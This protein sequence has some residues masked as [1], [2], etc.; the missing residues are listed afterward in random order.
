V[1]YDRMRRC[2][3]E[4]V[5][6]DDNNRIA[7][8]LNETIF[9]PAGDRQK[10]DRGSLVLSE[11]LLTRAMAE[12]A[13]LPPAF[14]VCDT[15]QEEGLIAHILAGSVD[16]TLIE[17]YVVG[18][19]TVLAQIDWAFRFSQ[20]RL[21]SS[22]HLVHIFI[23][24]TLGKQIPH[25][26]RVC[27]QTAKLSYEIPNLLSDDQLH[28]TMRLANEFIA[29]GHEIR[30]YSG[31]S[32]IRPSSTRIWHCAGW[33]I[34]CNGLHPVNTEEVGPVQARLSTED[35]RTIITLALS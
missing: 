20:M 23:E 31:G 8:F 28:E 26:Y 22:A 34:A 11:T 10:G 25:A 21:H 3:I 32:E 12:R 13:D 2:W 19:E 9:F 5:G 16:P 35:N 14:I 17:R 15:L 27:E 6:R 29:V 18:K 1:P 33:E 24:R 7:L 30:S 4:A